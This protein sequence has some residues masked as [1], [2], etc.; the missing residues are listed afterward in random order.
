MKFNGGRTRLSRRR[1]LA[2]AGAATA[3]GF[4]AI[5]RA[6]GPIALRW[7]SAWPAKDIFHEYALDIARKVSDMTGGE[8]KIEMLPAATIVP[9][10]GLLDAVSK[11]ALDAAHGVL[12][13][14]HTRHPALALWSSGPG[15]G[16]DANTLLAWHK[17]GGGRQLLAKIYAA[18]GANVVS[19]LYGA[20]PTQPLGLFKKRITKPEDFRGLTM[21]VLGM[22]PELFAALGA[23]VSVLT[24]REW[25]SGRV[26]A[27][28]ELDGVE[29][30]NPTSDR[31]LGLADIG[32]VYMMQSYHQSA[33]QFEIL[34]NKP[35]FDALP[36]KLRAIIENAV[37][38]ASADMSWK[39]I[40]RYSK[41]YS[42]MQTTEGVQS[43]RTP[44]AVLRKQIEAHETAARKRRS[45]PLFREVEE[46]QRRFARRAVRWHLDSQVSPRLAYDHYFAKKPAPGRRSKRK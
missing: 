17:Y 11:G 38:A 30:N 43:F 46:S 4:P 44:D 32:K 25:V 2:R 37:E 7:Q 26:G 39:A 15:F 41:D 27:T 12:E 3:L 42:E 14:H 10:S 35:K 33:Q 21:R 6:Q 34:F 45:D 22:S 5:G 19:L 8:L 36:P 29:F 28:P 40:D 16:M 9:A 20:M 31:G 18:I 24:P 23:K 1:F 13:Q